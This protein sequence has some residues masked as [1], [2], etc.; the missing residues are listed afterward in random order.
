MKKLCISR[1]FRSHINPFRTLIAKGKNW[2]E[3]E[4]ITE[5]ISSNDSQEWI[6]SKKEALILKEKITN[7]LIKWN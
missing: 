4:E 2:E 7:E 3:I 6:L 5:D 1:D